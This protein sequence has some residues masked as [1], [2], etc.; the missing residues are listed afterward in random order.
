MTGPDDLDIRLAA[1]EARV[2]APAAVPLLA[3][4][5]RIG[6]VAPFAAAPALAL[7]LAATAVAGAAITQLVH[8]SPGV[9]NQGQPL[10]GAGLEC[11]TPPQAAAYLAGRG[12]TSVVWQVETG[13]IA[14][15]T[16]GSTQVATPPVHGYVVPGSIVDG[17]L[18]MVV[19]Q[20]IGATGVGA[21]AGGTMP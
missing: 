11:M 18:I 5:R 21:C 2:P 14:S 3:R 17:R 15:K 12:Y 10:A 7:V 20:R 4:R 1:M 16:G 9:E 8:G 13:D 6:R 19:D